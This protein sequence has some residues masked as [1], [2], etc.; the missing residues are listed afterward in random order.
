MT[1]D[2]LEF[3]AFDGLPLN[4]DTIHLSSS[5]ISNTKSMITQK[6][7]TDTNWSQY[8]QNEGTYTLVGLGMLGIIMGCAILYD[9]VFKKK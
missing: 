6:D 7:G 8:H 5:E 3:K 4:S 1:Q 9:K 2:S